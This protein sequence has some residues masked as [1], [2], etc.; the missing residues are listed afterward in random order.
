MFNFCP[1]DYYVSQ[2]VP[3]WV[4]PMKEVSLCF[5]DLVDYFLSYR[6]VRKVFSSYLLKYFLSSFFSLFSFWDPYNENVCAFIF[7]FFLTFILFIYF[8]F[9]YFIFKLYIILLVL[10][11]I[12]MN[13]LQVYMCS[14]S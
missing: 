10:P 4:Y 3:P 11:N 1:F 5:P 8:L 14:P 2:C 7:L 12:K 13:P 6:K 9:F